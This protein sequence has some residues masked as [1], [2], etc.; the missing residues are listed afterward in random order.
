[1]TYPTVAVTATNLDAGTDSPASARSDL[2]DAVQKLNQ[3]IA[4]TTAFAATLLDDANA[5]TARATLG[6]AAAGANADITSFS[7]LSDGG[8]P[9]AK[10]VNAAAKGA[11]ADITSLT[12]ITSVPNGTI[13]NLPTVTGAFKNLQASATGSSANVTV[14]SDEIVLSNSSNQYVTLRTVSLTIAG[15]SV[16][17]NA[18]DAGTIATGTWYSVWVIWDG[19][20]TA[21]LLSTSA[22]APTLPSGYTHKAR[23]GWIKTDGTG[24][25]YPLAFK[26]YG[27]KVR[28]SVAGNVTGIPLI[29]GGAAAGSTA[30]PTYVSAQVQANS[31]T[32]GIIPSTAFIAA[33]NLAERGGSS[34]SICAPSSS[35]GAY[36]STSNPPP[37]IGGVASAVTSVTSVNYDMI[38]ESIN[39][40]FALY[41]TSSYLYLTGWEDN[42]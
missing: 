19:T 5:A 33:L 21:G 27:R 42:I 10:V 1:M 31:A 4:H 22:T 7:G 16:G 3:M 6:A 28:Y 8:I 18:L 17:A 25:K 40:F 29:Q 12:A 36:N 35:Y 38:L 14:T 15:T 32:T 41:G 30:V 37:M 39:V 20:T 34:Q 26:Q 9:L 11:N 2:L 13:T 24:N 23:V